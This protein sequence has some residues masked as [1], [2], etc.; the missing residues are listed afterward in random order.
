MI[1]IIQGW[2]L[3]PLNF[4]SI[5]H[6]LRQIRIRNIQPSKANSITNSLSY[7]LQTTLFIKSTIQYH[8]PREKWSKSPAN[9]A[10]LLFIREDVRR[11]SDFHEAYLSF[12]EFL[13]KKGIGFNRLLIIRI[14][15]YQSRRYFNPNPWGGII[16]QGNI[17]QLQSKSNPILHTS[18]I[19][20]MSLIPR[21]SQ[22]SINKISMS[23]MQLYPIEAC[24]FC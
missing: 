9:I 6:P 21:C 22:E 1:S 23:S 10:V 7:L 24:L 8:Q 20:I 11:L 13:K 2:I 3:L 12:L 16:F 19:M 18:T 17:S 5:Y 14:F 4:P 15:Y